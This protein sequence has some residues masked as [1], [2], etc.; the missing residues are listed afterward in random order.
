[1]PWRDFHVALFH[2]NN[3]FIRLYKSWK[4]QSVLAARQVEVHQR[5]DAFGKIL[6]LLSNV[7]AGNGIPNRANN[8]SWHAKQYKDINPKRII[9]V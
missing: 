1:M 7:V 2:H 3:S 5:Q 9:S 4:K 8:E 6:L